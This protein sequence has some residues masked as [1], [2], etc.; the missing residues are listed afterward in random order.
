MKKVLGKGLSALIPDTYMKEVEAQRELQKAQAQSDESGI[1]TIPIAQIKP[2]REQPRHRFPEEKIQEL[3][4]SIREQG[5]LQP[6][7]V[8]KSGEGYELICGER[9][10]RAA[11]HCGL[12]KISAIIKDVAEDKLLEWALV[13]NIQREDLNA[14]EE[15]QAYVRLIESHDL[16]HDQIAKKSG[17]GSFHNCQHGALASVATG[18]SGRPH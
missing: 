18:N 8:K 15:A 2:N 17:Q 7:I 3:A 9:R 1:Q 11:K 10:L 14:I 13:E 5:I 12:D 6:V 16:S 4:A